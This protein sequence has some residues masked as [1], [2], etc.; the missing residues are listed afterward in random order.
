MC[1]HTHPYR[2]GLVGEEGCSL[3]WFEDRK[4]YN[5]FRKNMGLKLDSFS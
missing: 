3:E 2:K 1:G 4:V 5:P